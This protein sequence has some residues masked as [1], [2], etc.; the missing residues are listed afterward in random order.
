MEGLPGMDGN[1]RVIMRINSP[2][3]IMSTSDCKQEAL[4][5]VM[6]FA[7]L[8]AHLMVGQQEFEYG[9]GGDTYGYLGVFE[10]RINKE[11]YESEK[12]FVLDYY[13]TEEQ[14]DQLRYLI[15]IAEPDTQTRQVI[16][17]MMMEEMDPY[18]NGNKDLDSACEILDSRVRLYLQ[19][20]Q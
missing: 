10:E 17:D 20:R 5:F 16:F 9:K 12:P 19:E 14:L 15:D 1:N 4:D 18:L 8:D 11:L 2:L 6:H 3:G 7:T 13:Y